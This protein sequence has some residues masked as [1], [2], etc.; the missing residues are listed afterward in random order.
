MI[1]GTDQKS[2]QISDSKS[3]K[4]TQMIFISISV[5]SRIKQEF[6][7]FAEAF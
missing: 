1:V 4:R 2:N 3:Q 7:V 6:F 5:K